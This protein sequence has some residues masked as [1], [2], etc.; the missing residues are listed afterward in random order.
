MRSLLPATAAGLRLLLVMTVLTGLL[1]PAAI[2]AAGRLPG[3]HG[4]A[5]GSLVTYDGRVVGSDLIGVDLVGDEWFHGRPSASAR[6]VLGPG[7]PSVSGGSNLAGDSAA[8]L[9]AVHRRRALIAARE[10]ADPAAVPPDAVTASASGLDPHISVAYALLQVPRVARENGLTEDRV[11]AL[12][13]ANTTDP[14]ATDPVVTVLRL[15]VAVA[16]A[17][18]DGG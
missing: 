13:A 5:E 7:D 2:W 10:N 16:G 15:N 18:G 4:N 3:L 11:R 9:A 1:Y 8:L 6:D 12:V 17:A 14:L